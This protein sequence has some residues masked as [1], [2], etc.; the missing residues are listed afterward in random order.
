MILPKINSRWEP[1]VQDSP[2]TMPPNAVVICAHSL[3]NYK[4]ILYCVEHTGH[5]CTAS[6]KDFLANW[7]PVGGAPATKNDKLNALATK[8]QDLTKG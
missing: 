6:Y 3:N 2:A 4:V 8:L 5:Y 7:Q 1:K